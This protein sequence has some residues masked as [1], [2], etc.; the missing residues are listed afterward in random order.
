MNEERREIIEL[1]L[2]NRQFCYSLLYHAFGREPDAAFMSLLLAENT[3][4]NFALLG[5]ETLECVPAFLCS[6]REKA[7]DSGFLDQVRAEYMRLFV[8]PDRLPAPPWESVYLGEDGTL[9]QLSTLEV[10]N[11]YRSFGLL[12]E[13]Y[14]RVADD[15]LALELGFMST[16]AS[17]ATDAFRQNQTEELKK[18]LEGSEEFLRKHLLRWIPKFLERLSKACS[19]GILYPKLCR[20]LDVF[21]KKDE[22]VLKEI[23]E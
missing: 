7:E 2:V 15:S 10:R 13:E 14:P 21:L 12:P 9:F 20:I 22:L 19:E 23:L 6:L 17:W 8:G 11:C 16:L 4:E 3:E 5:G 18:Y 1:L